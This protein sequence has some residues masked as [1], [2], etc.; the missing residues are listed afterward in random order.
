[1]SPDEWKVLFKAD[2]QNKPNVTKAITYIRSW[3]SVCRA[4]QVGYDDGN[5]YI[6]KGSQVGRSAFN[7]QV[8]GRIA[9]ELGAPVSQ[10]SLVQVETDLVASN[11]EMAHVSSGLAHGSLF[12]RDCTE[13]A[14]LQYVDLREN[15]PRFALLSVLYG[16][17]VGAEKQFF[18]SITPPNLVY[19]FDHD[20]FF[21]DG[22]NWS[23][24]SLNRAPYPD[25]DGVIV[26]QCGLRHRE[27]NEACGYL[28]RITPEIIALAIASVPAEWG[29]VDGSQRIVLAQ[30]L[31]QRC[32]TMR[33]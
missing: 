16:W 2:G 23:V 33:S 21:P 28:E 31:W 1:M 9:W 11:P 29:A 22:P 10:V 27:L 12:I 13:C 20:A 18:Y 24:Q 25:V 17:I 32:E 14:W 8:V 26:D 3:D 15:R 7:D 19:S 30:Y 4:V 5:D 6:I